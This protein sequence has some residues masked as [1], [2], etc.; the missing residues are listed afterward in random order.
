VK[1]TG[2]GF[3]AEFASVVDAVRSAV[4][5]QTGLRDRN[6]G[7]G[8]DTRLDFRIGIN[9][10]DVVEQDGDIF[11]DGVNVAARLEAIAEPGGI[12][13]SAR[14]EEDV[15]GRVDAQFEDF[16]EQTLKN[17]HRP[18]R[19]YAVRP[20]GGAAARKTAPPASARSAIAVLP[21]ANM[22]S[23]PEQDYFAEGIA[24]E[25]ITALSRFRALFVI[26]RNSSFVYRGRAVEV[27]QVGRELGVRYVL[28]GS[29]RKSAD[30]VRITGQ[31]VDAEKGMHLW[32]ERFDGELTDIFDLQ[33]RVTAM[34]VA[35]ITPKLEE[36]EIE[37]VQRKATGSLDAYDYYL[38]GMAAFHR[39]N[40]Q[41][42]R[43]ALALFGKAIALDPDFAAAHARAAACYARRKTGG[44]VTDPAFEIAEAE[45][46]A[47]RAGELARDDAVALTSAGI[48]LAYVVGDLDAGGAFVERA[49]ALNPNMAW[50]WF[51][52][53]W[54]KVWSGEPD[55]AIERLARAIELSPND[56]QIFNMHSSLAAAH[57]FAGRNN[58]ALNWARLALREQPDLTG[59]ASIAAAAAALA[60]DGHAARR[61]VA[62]LRRL[63]PKFQIA[64][65]GEHWPL[66]RAED[67]ALWGE[68]LRRAGLPE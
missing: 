60:G 40:R 53:G 66:R 29:V 45:R 12:C 49:L 28:E 59:A 39:W 51:C 62:E 3:L 42:N 54:V 10:G 56:P 22:S 41:S 6:A 57:F 61:A 50:A 18:I 65:L 4:E 23:D 16:G 17:I 55:A 52:G 5:I 68:G 33:D 43:E 37:R 9:V 7:E 20:P 25:I 38:R 64:T 67:L 44:W 35:A 14:V 31:L 13:I 36:A 1:T 48:T 30:R 46:F 2:D 32:A 24:E 21:F 26:S 27:K 8:A 58:E 15:A 34:T 47:R 63:D 11:G 19:V